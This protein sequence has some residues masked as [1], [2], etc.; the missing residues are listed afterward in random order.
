MRHVLILERPAQIAPLLLLLA[1]DLVLS[2]WSLL[3]SI[4]VL[5]AQEIERLTMGLC[6]CTCISC[7]I[8]SCVG[9]CTFAVADSL[10]PPSEPLY[11]RQLWGFPLWQVVV[12]AFSLSFFGLYV[13]LVAV[14]SRSV[15]RKQPWRFIYPT[16]GNCW[17]EG[18]PE[19]A[20]LGLLTGAALGIT[21]VWLLVVIL[22]YLFSRSR[23]PTNDEIK[24]E[25][26]SSD[27]GMGLV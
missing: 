5:Y 23:Q 26:K 1:C 12:C 4:H 3:R 13:P 22:S 15:E 18:S 25:Y 20:T 24:N 17:S 2:C 16:E 7:P 6:L 27:E 9:C 14:C 8:S 11:R 10:V 21:S 19:Y